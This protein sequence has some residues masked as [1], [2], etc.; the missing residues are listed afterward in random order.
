VRASSRAAR[1]ILHSAVVTVFSACC[2]LIL[3]IA[4]VTTLPHLKFRHL[5]RRITSLLS[6]AYIARTFVI[7]EWLTT[8]TAR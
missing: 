2:R 5:V 4:R 1:G 7:S 3:E 8:I 6:C